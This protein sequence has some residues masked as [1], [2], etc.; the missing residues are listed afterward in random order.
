MIKTFEAG[1]IEKCASEATH[2]HENEGHTEKIESVNVHHTGV[3]PQETVYVMVVVTNGW[4]NY[5]KYGA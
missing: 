2:W 3:Y 1:S 4:Y 5:A